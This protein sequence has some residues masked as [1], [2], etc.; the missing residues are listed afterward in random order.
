M[1]DINYVNCY[2][3]SCHLENSRV[4]RGEIFGNFFKR[5]KNYKNILSSSVFILSGSKECTNELSINY[6]I[7]SD[8]VVEFPYLP[9]DE[10]SN[11]GKT[12]LNNFDNKYLQNF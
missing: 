11:E 5:E 12:E 2:L 3:D 4:S 9:Q 10:F 8:K 1:K 6:N 7:K